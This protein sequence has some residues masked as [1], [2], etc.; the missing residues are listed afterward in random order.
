MPSAGGI[1]VRKLLL[2]Y[3]TRGYYLTQHRAAH[4]DGRNEIG[5]RVASG[6]Y[7]YELIIDSAPLPVLQKMLIVNYPS[8]KTW[9]CK[10]I[11]QQKLLGMLKARILCFVCVSRFVEGGNPLLSTKGSSC[12][13]KYV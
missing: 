6:I 11:K 2:G 10:S 1:L 13:I 4:W 7:F 5:E 12:P 8:L 3:Q 9:A